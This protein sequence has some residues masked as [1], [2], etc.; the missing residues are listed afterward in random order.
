M[1]LSIS[2]FTAENR[3]VPRAQI[4]GLLCLSEPARYRRVRSHAS[5][6]GAFSPLD[7]WEFGDEGMEIVQ[8]SFTCFSSHLH[9]IAF[10]NYKITHLVMEN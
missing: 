2:I 6:S 10:S 1:Q 7:F 8:M 5:R 9:L 4:P 3:C